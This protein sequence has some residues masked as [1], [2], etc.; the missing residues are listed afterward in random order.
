M[1][2]TSFC[3]G[4]ADGSNLTGVGEIRL[5]PD[6]PT[7]VRIPW[8]FW[9][10]WTFFTTFLN[11]LIT[12]GGTMWHCKCKHEE[13]T[14]QIRVEEDFNLVG[15]SAH[16]LNSAQ[17]LLKYTFQLTHP[18]QH[19]FSFLL[20]IVFCLILFPHQWYADLHSIAIHLFLSHIYAFEVP[21][22]IIWVTTTPSIPNC[23]SVCFF[24]VHNF[25]YAP[26]Y[27][28]CL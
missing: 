12:L 7:L 23:M 24:K 4:P 18:L 1:G 8:Y 13:R 3:D 14:T 27:M 10:F 26:T 20:F 19:L 28:L 11:N 16:Q 9:L 6:M 21:M 15:G 5:V 17:F 25:C 22:L 2:M